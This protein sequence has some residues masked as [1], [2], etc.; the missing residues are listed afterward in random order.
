MIARTTLK[1][2]LHFLDQSRQVAFF[3]VAEFLKRN[4]KHVLSVL[5]SNRTPK[6]VWENSEKL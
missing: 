3:L 1:D 4:R 2:N 5:S 6:N